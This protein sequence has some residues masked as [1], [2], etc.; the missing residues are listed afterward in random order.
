MCLIL[1]SYRTH[2]E[3]PLIVAA[4]RD[5]S[6]E[7]P[8]S[9]AAFWNDHPHIYGGRDLEQ[10]GTW[11]GITRQ[12]RFAAVTNFRDGQARSATARSRGELVGNYLAGDDGARAY[13][14]TVRDRQHHYNGFCLLAGDSSSLCFLSNRGNGIQALEPGVHG[15][16]NHLLNTPWQKVVDGRKVMSRL[17]EVAYADIPRMLFEF[18]A[19]RSV[20]PDS[21]LPDTGVGLQRE[22]ELSPAFIAG[23]R[24]GTR[25]STV[26]LVDTCGRVVFE[27]RSFGP[28]GITLGAVRRAFE[29]ETTFSSPLKA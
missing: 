29:P 24:Y 16:S 11:L 27:E 9:P 21:A 18:L 14:D 13:L 20:A 15:L 17:A 7:R 25:A 22:R 3:Y 4:N 23:E 1:V 8:A 10:G 2:P 28:G 6:Y 12:G 19:Q 5:E 26:V